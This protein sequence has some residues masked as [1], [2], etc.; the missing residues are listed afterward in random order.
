MSE[1]ITWT[2]ASNGYNLVLWVTRYNIWRSFYIR[3]FPQTKRATLNPN[4][5]LPWYLLI[6][7]GETLIV[8]WYLH[9][10]ETYYSYIN[11]IR[12]KPKYTRYWVLSGFEWHFYHQICSVLGVSII[13]FLTIKKNDASSRLYIHDSYNKCLKRWSEQACYGPFW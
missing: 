13:R 8:I 1:K 2:S 12:S 5:Q 10:S 4:R 7:L 9:V 6:F 3:I 11:C